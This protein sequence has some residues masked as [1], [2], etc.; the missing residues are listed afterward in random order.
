MIVGF[1]LVHLYALSLEAAILTAG[2]L[3]PGLN[4]VIKS[5]T[6]MLVNRY[7]VGSVYGI[8]YGYRGLDPA[9]A[10]MPIP[11]TPETVDSIHEAG[12]TILGSSRGAVPK[13][14]A[15]TN[16]SP[17]SVRAYCRTSAFE[18]WRVKAPMPSAA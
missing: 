7:G 18:A 14:S 10:L 13:L 8:P 2:G 1:L 16:C 4:E 6:I 12:G 11:L 9:N 3:C 5:L 17:F 15:T